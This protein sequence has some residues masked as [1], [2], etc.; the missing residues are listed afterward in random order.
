MHSRIKLLVC[1]REAY[2]TVVIRS[3]HSMNGILE[4]YTHPH[5]VLGRPTL[6]LGTRKSWES[7][8]DLVILTTSHSC[9]DWSIMW[10]P[11]ITSKFKVWKGAETDL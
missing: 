1:I 5:R 11:Q 9:T 2:F 6:H 8:G 3:F 7:K 10:E 4:I